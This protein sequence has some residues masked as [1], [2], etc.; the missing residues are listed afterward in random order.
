MQKTLEA[1]EKIYDF[2]NWL[3]DNNID[4]VFFNGNN[5]F[6]DIINRKYW[7]DCYYEPYESS[8]D[9]KLRD[10]F[11]KRNGG[12]HYGPDAHTHWADYMTMYLVDKKFI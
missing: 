1:H 3:S 4:H 5:T 8:F 6:G 7:G 11:K 2:H 9:H 12:Y 10:K